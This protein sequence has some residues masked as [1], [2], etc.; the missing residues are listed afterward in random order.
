MSVISKTFGE[1]LEE[2]RLLTGNDQADHEI[3]KKAVWHAWKSD[4]VIPPPEK[5]WDDLN[6]EDKKDFHQHVK[7]LHSHMKSTNIKNVRLGL[8]TLYGKFKR[9]LFKQRKKTSTKTISSVRAAAHKEASG[10]DD[11]TS[12]PKTKPTLH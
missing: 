6:S 10:P 2:N 8:N 11:I 9:G 7:D 12:K 5:H 4:G 3:L 1:Y